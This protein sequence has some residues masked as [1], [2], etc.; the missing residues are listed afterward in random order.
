LPIV[1]ALDRVEVTSD[2]VSTPVAAGAV[3]LSL[4]EALS[5]VPDTR[6]AR[7]VLHDVLAVLL[8]GSCAVLA[9][10]R[11]FA[12]VAE[13][14]H[15]AGRAVLEP[16]ESTIRRVLQQIDA[17]ELEA[18]L[19]MWALG[20]LAATIPQAGTPARE[21]RRVF[22]LDGKSVRGAPTLTGR[23]CVHAWCR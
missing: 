13:Y 18:A 23:S 19:Q 6:S 1:A 2:E 8:L 21:Q 14:A 4:V 20:Q 22:A 16:H 11:S 9:G 15:D 10:A 7:G 5:A 17:A 12:A 3:V